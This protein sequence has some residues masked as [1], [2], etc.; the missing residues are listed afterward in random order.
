MQLQVADASILHMGLNVRMAITS[1]TA[2]EVTVSWLH[3]CTLQTTHRWF[4]PPLRKLAAKCTV[5]H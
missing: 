4:Q 1:G 3:M 2:D 5:V